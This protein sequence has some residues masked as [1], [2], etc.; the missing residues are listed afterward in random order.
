M[1]GDASNRA[2]FLRGLSHGFGDGGDHGFIKYAV[3]NLVFIKAILGNHLRQVKEA[4]PFSE[5]TGL[6]PP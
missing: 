4:H 5:S 6:C 2:R 1:F 3:D